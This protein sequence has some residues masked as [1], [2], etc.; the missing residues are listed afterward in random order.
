MWMVNPK[1]MC[2]KHLLG[3]HLELHMFV[4]TLREGKNINGYVAKDLVEPNSI[5][6]RHEKLVEEMTEGRGYNHNSPISAWEVAVL[7]TNLPT[8]QKHHSIDTETSLQELLGRCTD[9]HRR[10]NYLKRR[11][12]L[13]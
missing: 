6:I 2:A 5:W 7:S 8:E 13:Y 3:E 11:Q 10:F 9:C 4:G 12:T 1:I